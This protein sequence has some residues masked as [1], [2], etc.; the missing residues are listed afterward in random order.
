MLG[1]RHNR[2][3]LDEEEADIDVTPVMNVFLVIVLLL[4][5]SFSFFN[6]KAINTS[7]P[8]LANSEV[9]AAPGSDIRLTVIVELEEKGIRLAAL[10]DDADAETLKRLGT[11]FSKENAQNYPLDKLSSYLQTLKTKYPKSDTVIII[12]EGSIVY[13]TI[14]QT[15]DVARYSKNVQ[16]FPHVVISGKVS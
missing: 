6:L 10:S 12:P 2:K 8:V 16:L 7:V 5:I 14:I 13:D 11:Y 1:S 9:V 4:L 15:M 3:R